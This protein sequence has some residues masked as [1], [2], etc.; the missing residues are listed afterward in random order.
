MFFIKKCIEKNRALS[1]PTLFH[2]QRFALSLVLLL[3]LFSTAALAEE[4]ETAKPTG[5]GTEHGS[6]GELGAKLSDPTSDVWALFTEFDFLWSHALP[7]DPALQLHRKF[8]IA[9]KAGRAGYIQHAGTN[10]PQSGQHGRFFRQGWFGRYFFA[11]SVIT[12]A[13]TWGRFFI[14]L[15]P[16]LSVSHPHFICTGHQYLG[17]RS[18]GCRHL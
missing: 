14:R 5:D 3:A 13:E 4:T 15:W 16:D 18:G 2:W 6:L 12:R 9:D 17:G 10:R 11:A 1:K 8:E 7:A